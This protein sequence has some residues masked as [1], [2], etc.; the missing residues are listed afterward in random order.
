[1]SS[2]TMVGITPND[3]DNHTP[4]IMNILHSLILK[5]FTKYQLPPKY[6]N[7]P[8][9]IAYIAKQD[10]RIKALEH[11]IKSLNNIEKHATKLGYEKGY[12]NAMF[13]Q[14]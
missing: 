14:S 3:L 12:E 10:D 11:E 9:L 7:D 13:D 6:E 5:F 8:N 2:R 4:T 1:M